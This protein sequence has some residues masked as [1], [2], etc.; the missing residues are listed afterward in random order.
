[1]QPNFYSTVVLLPD[2]NRLEVV[3]YYLDDKPEENQNEKLTRLFIQMHD[4]ICIMQIE[5]SIIRKENE[6][7][8]IVQNKVINERGHLC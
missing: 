2:E 4:C 3:Y 6:L 5:K 8:R 7:E 1:M